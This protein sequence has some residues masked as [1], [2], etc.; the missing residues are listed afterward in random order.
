MQVQLLLTLMSLNSRMRPLTKCLAM[1][2][3]VGAA[4]ACRSALAGAQTA[5]EPSECRSAAEV[6]Q[7]RQIATASAA[8]LH[9]LAWCPESAG[10]VVPALWRN[11]P[12]G[13]NGL[14]QLLFASGNVRDERIRRV[15]D[16]VARD[17]SQSL[18]VRRGAIGVLASYADRTFMTNVEGENNVNVV[19]VDH[20]QSIDGSQHLSPRIHIEVLETLRAIQAAEARGSLYDAA[21]YLLRALELPSK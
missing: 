17:S 5:A 10:A 16:A 21:T 20:P 9:V 8:E 6:V 7:Q 13:G 3:I 15:V 18:A 11:P 2:G 14:R 19:R 12:S 1:L 4:T